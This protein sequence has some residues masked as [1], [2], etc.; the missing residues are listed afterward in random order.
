MK[1]IFLIIFLLVIFSNSTFS[2]EL[3]NGYRYVMPNEIKIGKSSTNGLY[4]FD[5]LPQ[6]E[7]NIFLNHP[8]ADRKIINGHTYIN[9]DLM[10]RDIV[11][12]GYGIITC[13]GDC[14]QEDARDKAN[15]TYTTFEESGIKRDNTLHPYNIFQKRYIDFI[16]HP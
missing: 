12:R 15:S 13:S 3:I 9:I 4:Y 7:Q 1:K 5:Q 10:D 6:W 14:R 2:M 11:N 8:Q 16:Y